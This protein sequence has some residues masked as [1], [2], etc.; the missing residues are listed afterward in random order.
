MSDPLSPTILLT[1]DDGIDAPGLA[2]LRTELTALGDVTVVA[3]AANQSGV[4]RT[5]SHAAVIR[6]HPWGHALAGTPADCVAYGLRGLDTEFDVVVSGVNNGPNAGN[7][8]VGRSGTVGAGIEAAFLGTPA[9]AISGY[10][11]TDFFLSPPEEYDFAR[12]ARIA[13]RLVARALDAGVYDDVDLLNVNA[14]V[15]A[16][17]PPVILTEPYHDYEQDVE[18]VGPDGVGDDGALAA[19]MELD[20]VGPEDLGPDD[21]IVR[22]KDQTW[23]GVVG[24]ESPFPPTDEH[25]DRYP[26]GTDR[27]AMVD[28]A[29]SVSPLAVTHASPDSAALADVVETISVE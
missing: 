25:R 15:D 8:V 14:P 29:V 7:Y 27:R 11:S 2:T 24:W 3:P 19:D 1:N 12:P 26:V 16:S 20:G 10:H 9:L 17:S 4:G 22:L 5:R 18:E 28:A 23:P 6:D 13:R 21:R